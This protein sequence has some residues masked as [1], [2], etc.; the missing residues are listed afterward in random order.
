MKLTAGFQRTEAS[1]W[2]HSITW[3]VGFNS[4]FEIS[5]GPEAVAGS[6]T[7][8][9]GFS[10]DVGGQHSWGKNTET[11]VSSSLKLKVPVKPRHSTKGR[12][13]ATQNIADAPYEAKVRLTYK[14][15]STRIVD[16]IGE[17]KGVFY[18]DFYAEI[19]KSIPL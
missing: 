15:G 6:V 19:D 3:N 12:I 18:S 14:D 4:N 10:I 11:T 5:V 9:F 7:Q 8:S 13:V 1:S 16:D 2:Q 17:W